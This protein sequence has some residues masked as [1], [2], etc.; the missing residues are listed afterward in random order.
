MASGRANTPGLGEKK[1]MGLAAVGELRNTGPKPSV[2]DKESN[3]VLAQVQAQANDGRLVGLV[4]LADTTQKLKDLATKMM[5]LAGIQDQIY[6]ET[7]RLNQEE[8]AQLDAEEEKRIVALRGVLNSLTS[9]LNEMA[10][11][12]TSLNRDTVEAMV[13]IINQAKETI[14]GRR[15]KNTSVAARVEAVYNTEVRPVIETWSVLVPTAEGATALAT[16]GIAAPF[17]TAAVAPGTVVPMQITLAT[18]GLPPFIYLVLQNAIA[19]RVLQAG[20]LIGL[21]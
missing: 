13:D 2:V 16:A 19:N 11:T 4:D 14:K 8:R 12:A 9:E 17:A 10:F 5:E 7:K 15:K 3:Q 1:P 21:T 18:T 6:D 20:G